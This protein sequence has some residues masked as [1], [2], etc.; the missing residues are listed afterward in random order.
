MVELVYP[1]LAA[2]RA[3]QVELAAD[4]IRTPT[5]ACA[6]SRLSDALGGAE[7]SLKMELFQHTG[8]FKARGALSCVAAIF[9]DLFCHMI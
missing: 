2:M 7:V 6:S 9:C 4:V 1:D 8:S 5:V 3:R